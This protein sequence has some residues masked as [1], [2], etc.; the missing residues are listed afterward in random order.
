MTCAFLFLFEAHYIFSREPPCVFIF[1]SALWIWVGHAGIFGP[2]LQINSFVLFGY[3]I[4]PIINNPENSTVLF[5]EHCV[6][7]TIMGSSEVALSLFYMKKDISTALQG[8]SEST[9]PPSS[10]DSPENTFPHDRLWKMTTC[11]S[12]LRTQNNTPRVL[13]CGPGGWMGVVKGHHCFHCHSLD[14]CPISIRC[15][16]PCDFLT[17][18]KFHICS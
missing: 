5:N 17:W 10:A 12:T 18:M 14:T 1:A 9:V 11:N 16:N 2:T 15:I 13:M 6:L 8:N 4:K 7:Y 3:A